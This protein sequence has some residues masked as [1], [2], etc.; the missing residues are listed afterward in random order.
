MRKGPSAFSKKKKAGLGAFL[1]TEMPEVCKNAL[2][3]YVNDN[4]DNT[5]RGE[6]VVRPFI[7]AHCDVAKN[8][9]GIWETTG[10][11]FERF[12]ATPEGGPCGMPKS[13]FGKTLVRLGFKNSG[14][15]KAYNKETGKQE[16]RMYGIKLKG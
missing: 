10:R 2:Q 3:E 8:N 4:G 13:E 14:K 1:R 6:E 7:D 11:L 5:D 12:K 16:R 9:G 15:N